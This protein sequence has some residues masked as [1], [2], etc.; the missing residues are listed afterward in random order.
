MKRGEGGTTLL[1]ALNIFLLLFA[2]YLLKVTREPLILRHGA[3]FKTYA[4]SFQAITLMPALIGFAWASQHV[5]RVKL[6]G[7]STMVISSMLLVFYWLVRVDS[8]WAGPAFFV[9][10]GVM[11][12]F[13]VSQF[14]AFANDLFN[15][16][17]GIRL[18]GLIGVGSSLGALLGPLAAKQLF[19]EADPGFL[20]LPAAFLIVLAF[21]VTLLVH[22][23]SKVVHLGAGRSAEEPLAKERFFGLGKILSNGYFGAIA[24]LVLVYNTVNT[25]GE[26]IKDRTILAANHGGHQDAYVAEFSSN[27]F[28]Y[29][30]GLALILQLFFVSRFLRVLKVHRALYVMP[31]ISLISY[32]SMGLSVVLPVILWAKVAENAA[33][34]SI[35][36]TTRQ[37]LFLVAPREAKYKVKTAIDTFFMRLGDVFAG[38]LLFVATTFFDFG[39]TSLVVTN[40]ALIGVWLLLARRVGNTY[41]TLQHQE[42]GAAT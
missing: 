39:R 30:N 31:L 27:F 25:L 10:V 8:P 20:M 24:L 28:L 5:P 7:L 41:K 37:A 18:F 2:Y 13:V 9:F 32:S 40:L 22:K 36:T 35:Q 15:E 26:N 29:V 19:N 1:L 14:W 4:S 21:V 11:N 17:Q 42:T 12:A 34:Y 38:A 33:D 6:I 23:R 16:E 3:D